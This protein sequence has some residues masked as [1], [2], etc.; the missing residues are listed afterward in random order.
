M[1]GV[2]RSVENVEIQD[3]STI[4][5][6]DLSISEMQQ[7]KDEGNVKIEKFSE[8][9]RKPHDDGILTLVILHL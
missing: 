9:S 2:A 3:I 1:H 4:Q 7:G 5:K 6:A 8:V